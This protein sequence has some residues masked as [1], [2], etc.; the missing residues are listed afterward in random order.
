MENKIK[1]LFE[2]LTYGATY[3]FLEEGKNKSELDEIAKKRGIVLPSPDLALFKCT[4]AF[5]D[6][7]NK[8]G[9]TLL[10]DEAIRALDTLAMKE[11]D[12]DHSRRRAV[13]VWLDAKIKG[14]TIIAYGAFWKY[15]FKEEYKDM[16]KQIEEGILSVSFE[17]WGKRTY[18]SSRSYDFS[19]IHFAGGALL[20]RNE[21]PAF[22][23]AEVLEFASV[24]A[25]KKMV[26]CQHCKKEFDY[27]KQMEYR[28]GSVKC[29]HCQAI[30][31]QDGGVIKIPQI[32]DFSVRCPA[33]KSPDN[34]ITEVKDEYT[35]IHCNNCNRN[36]KLKFSKQIET[37]KKLK[38]DAVSTGLAPCPSCGHEVVYGT[39]M[40]SKKLD[41]RC[42]KCGLKFPYDLSNR[43]N[44]RIT[45]ISEI[46]ESA[47]EEDLEKKEQNMAKEKKEKATVEDK[48]LKAKE[49]SEKKEEP[50]PE[51]A[52][53]EKYKAGILKF[54]K[55]IKD[56]RK[57]VAE[58]AS[59]THQYEVELASFKEKSKKDIE[60]ANAKAETVKAFYMENAKKIYERRQELGEEFSKGMKDE[61][62]LDEVKF[63]NATLKKQLA[64][65]KDADIEN[66]NKDNKKD[67]DLTVGANGNVDS[68]EKD[69]STRRKSIKDKLGY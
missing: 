50:K 63:E 59:A 67:E 10:H 49:A 13:G 15:S 55:I 16:K 60:E 3:E 8:N 29:P 14:N 35:V 2:D 11:I 5:T 23:G 56:L 62:I 17:A 12:I 39:L 40:S 65:K 47:K 68:R 46:L 38:L 20:S 66:A 7:E 25:D 54:A 22:D 4:Y 41:L 44:R 48:D 58:Y 53:L 37:Y 52:K 61:D 42:G 31:N 6:R 45:E 36:W 28:P 9:C 21:D 18:K 1:L 69:I 19:N 24:M 34:D 33:C 32:K 30:L 64:D 57:R 26:V 43:R 27:S 51:V